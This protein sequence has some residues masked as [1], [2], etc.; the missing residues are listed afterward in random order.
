MTE[1]KNQIHN[2]IKH[3]FINCDPGLQQEKKNR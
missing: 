2:D 3:N 1:K